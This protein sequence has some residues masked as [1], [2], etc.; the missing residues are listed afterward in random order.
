M[1]ITTEEL[2]LDEITSDFGESHGIKKDAEAILAERKEE[3]YAAADKDLEGGTLARRTVE[4][5]EWVEDPDEWVATWHPGWR[6]DP[7]AVLKETWK[8]QI[9]EI[10]SLKKFI[11][12]NAEDG[13]VYIRNTVQG[14]PS[15]DDQLLM[16]QDPAL[17]ERVSMPDPSYALLW[18]F[19][20]WAGGDIIHETVAIYLK[21]QAP[22]ILR[23][24]EELD[25]ET[26]QALQPYIAPGPLS[27]KMEAPRKAKPEELEEN[28]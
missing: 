5:P 17:W 26:L 7:E 3:F 12:I 15:L 25:E 20:K 24:L 21:T 16:S 18:E 1:A 9:E 4:I 13:K 19:S 10:P 23:P 22:R 14:A 27:V 2:T 6:I 28:S 8:V 11:H